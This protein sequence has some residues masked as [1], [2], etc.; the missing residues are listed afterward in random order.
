MRKILL[1]TSFILLQFEDR[2]DIRSQL[3]NLLPEPTTLL[4]ASGVFEE[5]KTLAG[6]TGKKSTAARFAIQNLEKIFEGFRLEK[7]QSKGPVDEWILNYAQK[8]NLTVATNDATLRSRLKE[9]GIPVIS[10]RSRVKLDFV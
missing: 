10:S 6:K 1:D 5:L 3:Q 7:V 4:L 9:A 2:L 8:N